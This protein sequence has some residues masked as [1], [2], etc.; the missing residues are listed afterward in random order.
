M[1]ASNYCRRS[2]TPHP[3]TSASTPPPWLTLIVCKNHVRDHVYIRHRLPAHRTLG[4]VGSEPLYNASPWKRCKQGKRL[5]TWSSPTLSNS[6]SK[7]RTMITL[8]K[9]PSYLYELSP[10]PYWLPADEDQAA[11][12]PLRPRP[13]GIGYC[14]KNGDMLVFRDTHAGQNLFHDVSG[15][16]G[17]LLETREVR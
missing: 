7:W 8:L 2:P 15:G 17:I 14:F 5:S 11:P 10:N 9:F 4:T 1:N 3:C 16:S 6:S 13:N 12:P